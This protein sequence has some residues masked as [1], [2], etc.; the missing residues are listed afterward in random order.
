MQFP[1]DVYTTGHERR[2]SVR[3]QPILD[4]SRRRGE[5]VELSEPETRLGGGDEAVGIGSRDRV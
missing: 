3:A 5:H 1:I 4:P 2:P